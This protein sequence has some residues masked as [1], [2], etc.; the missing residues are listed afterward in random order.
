MRWNLAWVSALQAK[1]LV[2]ERSLTAHKE[3]GDG[4]DFQEFVL[5]LL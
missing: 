5:F 4:M 3:Q 1:R 2:V